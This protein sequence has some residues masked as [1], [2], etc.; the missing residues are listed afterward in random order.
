MRT[1]GRKPHYGVRFPPR[2]HA[3]LAWPTCTSPDLHQPPE[4]R[5]TPIPSSHRPEV[6]ADRADV[7]ETQDRATRT[8]AFARESADLPH[9]NPQHCERKPS[10]RVPTACDKR[11]TQFFEDDGRRSGITIREPADPRCQRIV[12]PDQTVY[13]RQDRDHSP[14]VAMG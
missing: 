9:P 2:L 6:V 7:D 4:S 3:G 1:L 10:R 8:R 13:G 11:Q 14:Q 5:T 12:L